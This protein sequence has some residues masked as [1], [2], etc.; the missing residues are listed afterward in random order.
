VAKIN[1]LQSGTASLVY[2]SYLGGSGRGGD[3]GYGIAVD[4]LGNAYLTGETSSTDFPIKNG[5]QA[6]FGGPKHTSDAFV[7]KITSS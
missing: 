5:F 7:T 6:K 2:A 4:N 3:Q 1:S